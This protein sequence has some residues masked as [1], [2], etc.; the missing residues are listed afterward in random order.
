V[1]IYIYI[2]IYVCVCVCLL[3]P[4]LLR[5]ALRLDRDSFLNFE[6]SK[7]RRWRPS[8]QVLRVLRG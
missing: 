1:L 8:D 5:F 7:I 3:V 2:Y 4:V 6:V